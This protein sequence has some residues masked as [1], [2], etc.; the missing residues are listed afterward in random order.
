MHLAL[1]GA[2]RQTWTVRGAAMKNGVRLET[3]ARTSLPKYGNPRT[4]FRG[5]VERFIPQTSFPSSDDAESR[6]YKREGN[7]TKTPLRR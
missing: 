7:D 2:S 1:H 6:F 5:K 3:M 4:T